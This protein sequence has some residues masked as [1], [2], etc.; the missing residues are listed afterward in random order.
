MLKGVR[1]SFKSKHRT[2]P[3]VSVTGRVRYKR[4]RIDIK[5]DRWRI[6]IVFCE[7]IEHSWER[8]FI[9]FYKV[10]VSTI[11][12]LQWRFQAFVVVLSFLFEKKLIWKACRPQNKTFIQE[13]RRDISYKRWDKDAIGGRSW[14]T[15]SPNRNICD[16]GIE[17]VTSVMNGSMKLTV[18]A[19]RRK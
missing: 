10:P 12:L 2:L 14:Y 9:F 15:A 18:P 1:T 19:V 4:S 8:N 6:V 17:I 13:A 7:T 11:T 16:M 5:S 3:F